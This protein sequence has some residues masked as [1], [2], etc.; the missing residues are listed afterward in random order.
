MKEREIPKPGEFYRHFKKKYYQIIAVA[1]HSET[2]EQMVVYQAL[3]DDFGMYV[4]PLNMF[5]SKV[6]RKKYPDVMQEYRFERVER[7]CVSVELLEHFDTKVFHGEKEDKSIDTELSEQFVAQAEEG[8]AEEEET[9]VLD[10][11]V[12]RFLDAETYKDKLSILMSLHNHITDKQLHD[13]AITLDITI[14]EGSLDEK[15]Q[16]FVQCLRTMARFEIE[17]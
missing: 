9:F 11:D 14:E 3:Y 7:P 13:M 12:E 2:R 8:T 6:D 1:T 16:N 15:Y 17:R 4:R 5:L 10:S